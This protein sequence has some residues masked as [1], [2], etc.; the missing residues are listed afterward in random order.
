MWVEDLIRERIRSLNLSFEDSEIHRLIADIKRWT[1][2]NY[3]DKLLKTA[4]GSY[5]LFS[6]KYG[7]PYHSV[8]AGAVT[9]SIYKFLIPSGL[10]NTNK[11]S[12]KIL[13]I[14]F[15]L[16]YNVTVALYHIKQKNPEIYVEVISFE[17]NLLAEIPPLPA[18]YEKFHE[19]ILSLVPYGEKEGIKFTLLEGDARLR[20]KEVKSFKA[21]AVFHDPFSPYKNPELWTLEF[22]NEIKKRMDQKGIWVS[23]TSSSAVREALKRLGFRVGSSTPVGRKSSGTVASLKGKVP[24]LSQKEEEK[25]KRS[26]Y[27]IPFRDPDLQ[28]LPIEILI[29]YRISVLLREKQK[30]GA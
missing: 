20:I 30:H 21:D 11:K 10:L 4:D 7:E 18:P 3:A 6:G 8:T 15:G 14:G 23:Y 1:L 27:S 24:P 29:D 9:E 19:L 17:K 16:G 26:P 2:K 12:I 25:L 13:D 5:T 28:R 22:L